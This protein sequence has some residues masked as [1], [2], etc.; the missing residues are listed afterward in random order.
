[1]IVLVLAIILLVLTALTLYSI[2]NNIYNIILSII[3]ISGIG[4]MI[5]YRY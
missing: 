5:T 4:Y 1:M 2:K 3:L